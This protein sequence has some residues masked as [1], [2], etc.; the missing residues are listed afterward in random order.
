ML[1]SRFEY[2]SDKVDIEYQNALLEVQRKIEEDSNTMDFIEGEDDPFE[3]NE[4]EMNHG[5]NVLDSSMNVSDINASANGSGLL[6]QSFADENETTQAFPRPY[7]RQERQ[8]TDAI[9]I[10]CTRVAVSAQC[11]AMYARKA[12]QI[13]CK[14]MYGMVMITT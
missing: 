8:L 5:N 6:R 12:V 2:T 1:L 13:V 3:D 4:Q 9:K 7:I 11:S 10:A 14:D